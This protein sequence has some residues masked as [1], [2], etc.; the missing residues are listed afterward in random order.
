MFLLQNMAENKSNKLLND[1]VIALSNNDFAKAKELFKK[2]IMENPENV[3]A[4]YNLGAVEINQGNPTLALKTYHKALA[5]APS[6]YEV[7]YNIGTV[8]LSLGKIDKAIEY[9]EKAKSINP[10]YTNTLNNLG[11]AYQQV[12]RLED[13]IET[14]TESLEIRELPSTYNNIGVAQSKKGLPSEAIKYFHKAISLQNDDANAFNNLGNSHQQLGSL[15]EAIK[16]YHEAIKIEPNYIE[17]IINLASCYQE[18]QKLKTAQKY[19]WQAHKLAPGN[20]QTLSNLA[21]LL[22]QTCDWKKLQSILSEIKKNQIGEDPLVNI[23][24]EDNPKINYAVAKYWSDAVLNKAYLSKKFTYQKTSKKLNIGYIN[25]FQDKPVARLINDLFSSHNKKQFKI[26]CFSYGSAPGGEFREHVAK[27][28]NVFQDIGQLTNT[29]AAALINKN[30]IDILIDLKGYTKG[31]RMDILALRPAPIQVSYLGYPGTTGASFFDYVL[32]DKY[33]T[34]PNQQKYY[35]ENHVY[36]PGSYQIFSKLKY[37]TQKVTRS[38]YSLPKDSFVFSSLNQTLKIDRT[39][40]SAWIRIIKKVPHSVL[41]LHE[42]NIIAK[43]NLRKEAVAAG[44][45]PDRLIFAK[46]VNFDNHMSRI[47]LADLAL[48]TRIYSSGATANHTLSLGVALVTIPGK[49]Y[50]SRMSS[51]LVTSL[52]LKT[53]VAKNISDY[54]N[55]AISL[56]N[57]PKKLKRVVDKLKIKIKD[58]PQYNTKYFANNLE[59]AYETMW[60][61][62]KKGDLKPFHVRSRNV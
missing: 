31:H 59:S 15:K 35:S 7:I 9:F 40:F 25:N 51:S 47:P 57:D 29:E 37:Q 30:K 42:S 56:A 53:L 22:Q 43:R 36:M 60:K 6:D 20:I 2:A 32:T 45:D 12:G 3:D 26:Y 44:L 46:T 49:H 33:L 10:F 41:W 54:Q 58:D 50:L 17:A 23:M 39:I 8:Y 14:L 48:D 38:D 28:C 18:T 62:Y 16:N 24:H 21:H 11:V 34:P 61:Q 55:I 19:Y 1:G 4:Y 52:G 27:T 5:L 13:S